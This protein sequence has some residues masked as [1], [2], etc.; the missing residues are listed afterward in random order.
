MFDG[1]DTDES[2]FITRIDIKKQNKS[3]NLNETIQEVSEKLLNLSSNDNNFDELSLNVTVSSFARR[4]KQ[5][6][7]L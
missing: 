5:F 6:S 7:V 4:S 2:S 3:G 1:P